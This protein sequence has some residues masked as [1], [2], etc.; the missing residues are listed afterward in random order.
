MLLFNS[1]FSH[2]SCLILKNVVKDL[3]SLLM[4]TFTLFSFNAFLMGSLNHTVKGNNIIETEK[5]IEVLAQG[6]ISAL[7]CYLLMSFLNFTNSLL[8]I[9]NKITLTMNK[10]CMKLFDTLYLA[11]NQISKNFCNASIEHKN[12][13]KSLE[14]FINHVYENRQNISSQFL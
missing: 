13:H 8:L 6:C 3:H 14:F 4:F 11:M 2:Q 12:N 10:T 1:K 9:S 5:M 7:G